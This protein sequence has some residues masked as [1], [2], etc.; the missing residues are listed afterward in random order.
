MKESLQTSDSQ[1][2]SRGF[3]I[4]R[5][6]CFEGPL[7]LLLFLIQANELNISTISVA[8]V[9]SQYLVYV[10]A[11]QD[12]NFDLAS[13]F[14]VMAATLLFWKSRSLLPEEEN[15][16]SSELTED[17]ELTSP[18][19]LV[20]KLLERQ[21]YAKAAG[22]IAQQPWLGVDVFVRGNAKPPVEKIWREMDLT[23]LTLTYQD[24]YIR[25][26]R[27][28]QVLKKETVSLAR[29]M[30][31][32]RE[33]LSIGHWILL[34][35]LAASDSD[36]SEMVVTFLASLELGRLLKLRL[37]QE[38]IYTPIYVELIE[39]L[40]QFDFSLATG[41]VKETEQK[42]KSEGSVRASSNDHYHIDG[43]LSAV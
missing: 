31:E 8:Q 7:D 3:W 10:K 18:Q 1:Q 14:L 11:M 23:Q 26:N 24:I 29:K 30:E 17:S 4:V 5:Q 36:R 12:L 28:V 38:G 25:S 21:I 34:N 19:D 40:H 13:D 33:K 35:Q 42:T 9:T 6:N 16:K 2:T 41:F 20:R 27:R 15:E 43:Q 39:S 32:F 22:E 37:H